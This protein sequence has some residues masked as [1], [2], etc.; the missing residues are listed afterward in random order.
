[1]IESRTIDHL[2]R[3][4]TVVYVKHRTKPIDPPDEPFGRP[5]THRWVYR[6]TPSACQVDR[7]KSSPGVDRAT[8]KRNGLSL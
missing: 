3:K 6:D 5:V 1:M 8:P 2:N 4:V 7:L